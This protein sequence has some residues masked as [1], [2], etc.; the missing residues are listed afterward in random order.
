MF[1]FAEEKYAIKYLIPN[2]SIVAFLKHFS[3]TSETIMMR[4]SIKTT[5]VSYFGKNTLNLFEILIKVINYGF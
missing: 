2:F 4:S 5:N 3:S 1:N